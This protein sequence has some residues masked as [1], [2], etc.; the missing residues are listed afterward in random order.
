[1]E[2]PVHAEACDLVGEIRL[3]GH[4]AFCDLKDL[5]QL[6]L[7]SLELEGIYCMETIQK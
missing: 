7:R 1:M 3:T 2:Q 6:E 5:V 4:N